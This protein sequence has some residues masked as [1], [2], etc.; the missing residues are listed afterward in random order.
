LDLSQVRA[1]HVVWPETRE[2]VDGLSVQK[3]FF[4]AAKKDNDFS[5]AFGCHTLVSDLVIMASPKLG[6]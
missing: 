5:I 2:L 6:G 3:L 4:A 1:S